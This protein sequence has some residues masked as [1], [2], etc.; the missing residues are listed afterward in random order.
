[1]SIPHGAMD[2]AQHA[3][4]GLRRAGEVPAGV[5][6]SIIEKSWQRCL[7]YGLDGDS[8]SEYDVLGFDLLT[9]HREKNHQLVHHA[10]PVI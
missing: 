2:M 10:L 7:A 6:P 5:L 9:D 1:M 4:A 3:R 8:G